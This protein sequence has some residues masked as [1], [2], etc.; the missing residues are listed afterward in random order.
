MRREKLGS[1]PEFVSLPDIDTNKVYARGFSNMSGENAATLV[2]GTPANTET[3][4]EL[5]LGTKLKVNRASKSL[6]T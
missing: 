1:L 5:I 2:E 6:R 3:P 4:Y